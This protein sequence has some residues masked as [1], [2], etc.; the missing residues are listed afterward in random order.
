MVIWKHAEVWNGFGF[1]GQGQS[2]KTTVSFD[3][4]SR[5]LRDGMLEMKVFD[6][7]LLLNAGILKRDIPQDHFGS[8]RLGKMVLFQCEAR[9]KGKQLTDFSPETGKEYPVNN[10]TIWFLLPK[11]EIKEPVWKICSFAEFL[12]T[13]AESHPCFNQE[14]NPTV[15]KLL[16]SF[17]A[18]WRYEQVELPVACKSCHL[19]ESSTLDAVAEAAYKQ[20][21]TRILS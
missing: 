9:I 2:G 12:R 3:F 13:L 19:V 20:Y 15:E 11:V 6:D 4:A 1:F 18:N 21:R 17:K 10:A 16:P 14:W 7:R 8:D 5:L